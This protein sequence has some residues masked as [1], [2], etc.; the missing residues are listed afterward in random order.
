MRTFAAPDDRTHLNNLDLNNKLHGRYKCQR[1][2]QVHKNITKPVE[3]TQAHAG[4][5]TL[6]AN[7][8]SN[9]SNDYQ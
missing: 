3:R 1:K 5:Q 9:D 6:I 8:N 4:T 2:H 7:M